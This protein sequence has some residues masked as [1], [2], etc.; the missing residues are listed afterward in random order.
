MDSRSEARK[1]GCRYHYDSFGQ[2]AALLPYRGSKKFDV[3]GSPS[4]PCITA[5]CAH[6]TAESKRRGHFESRLWKSQFGYARNPP[7]KIKIS[8]QHDYIANC[9]AARP[10]QHEYDHVRHFVG[11]QQ[12]SRLSCFPQLL[13]WPIR[14]ECAD[15]GAG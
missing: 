7:L 14:E 10:S 11:L 6:R 9:H 1:E 13:R 2:R 12:T 15:D 4:R 5:L 8:R 3:P